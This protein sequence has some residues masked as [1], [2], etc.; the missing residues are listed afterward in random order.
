M[1][2][3]AL[4]TPEAFGAEALVFGVA[5]F[6]VRALHLVLYI[7]AGRD[8]PEL[9]PRSFASLRARSSDRPCW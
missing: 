2:I 7:I 6:L 4:A 9:R 1:L 3:V 8:D 5:Y